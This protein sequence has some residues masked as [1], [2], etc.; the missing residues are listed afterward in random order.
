MPNRLGKHFFDN[1]KTLKYKENS[2][3]LENLSHTIKLISVIIYSIKK[4]SSNEDLTILYIF[5][6]MFS[7]SC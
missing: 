6:G 4:K 7:H 3:L 2:P 5:L 1:I